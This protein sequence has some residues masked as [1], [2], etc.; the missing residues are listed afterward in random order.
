MQ[1][2]LTSVDKPLLSAW[3]TMCGNLENVTIYEGSILDQPHQAIVSPANSYGFMN[4]GIDQVYTDFFGPSLQQTLQKQIKLY[5]EGILLVGSAEVVNTGNK[6]FPLL[7]SAPTMMVPEIL[8]PNTINPYLAARAAILAA[9]DYGITDLAFPGLGTGI[10]R[11][12]PLVCA[13]QVSWAIQDIIQGAW[14]FPANLGTALVKEGM[15]K[16]V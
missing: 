4:G 10:G 7:V 14:Q 12:P 6:D 9:R 15:M 1:V 13:K 16:K 2:T 8:G 5:H 3:E 11:V